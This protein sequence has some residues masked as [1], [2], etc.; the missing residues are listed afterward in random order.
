MRGLSFICAVDEFQQSA[1]ALK[2]SLLHQG[3]ILNKWKKQVF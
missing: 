2:I 1:P 3:V